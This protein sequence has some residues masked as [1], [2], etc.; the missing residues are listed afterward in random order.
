M[1]LTAI[2]ALRYGALE[3]ECLGELSE[4]LTVVL[5]PNESGKSTMTA[6]TRHVLY[7]YPDGRTKGHGYAPATGPRAARLVFADASGE[8][9]IERV[10]GKNRGPVSVAARRGPERPGLLGELVSGVSEQSYQVV[11]GFGLDELAQDRERRQRRHR[12]A[13]VRRGLRAGGQPDGCAQAAG[14]GGSRALRAARTEAGGQ[15]ATRPASAISSCASPRSRRR[16]PS[17][18][19]S[20]HASAN[21]PSRSPRCAT[22][23]TI[24]TRSSTCSSR[25]S[26]G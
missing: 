16:R 12:L 20:R 10:D 21:S 11:F 1:R 24:S 14:G 3:G 19:A 2:E 25:I 4:G 18:R 15:R 5:G 22:A 9:A 13:A 23:E 17:T 7:G 8:W 6:L 26:R